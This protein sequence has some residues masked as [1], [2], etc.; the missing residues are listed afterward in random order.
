MG[1]EA[2]TFHQAHIIRRRLRAV[3]AGL[4]AMALMAAFPAWSQSDTSRVLFGPPLAGGEAEQAQTN[5]KEAARPKPLKSEE[6]VRQTVS[7][8]FSADPIAPKTQSPMVLKLQIMLDRLHHSPGVIDGYDGDNLRKALA[9]YQAME[10]IESTGQLD[11]ALWSRMVAA[12][13][14]ASL[15]SYVIQPA[16]VEGPFEREIP[17]DYAEAAKLK[18][19]AYRGVAEA[20]AERYHMDEDLLRQINPGVSFDKAGETI[21]V[22]DVGAPI[23]TKVAR[24]VADKALK[25]LRG[26]DEAGKLVVAYPATIGSEDLPSPSG[27]HV[28]KTVVKNPDYSYRPDVNFKQGDNDKPLRLAPG[29]NNP[30][31]SVWIGL[32]APTYGIHGTPEPSKI[33]KTGSHGCVRLTNWDA[34]ELLKLVSPGVT[35]EFMGGEETTTT[36]VK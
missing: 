19:M 3:T 7:A 29:P 16:D 36:A 2:G 5:A 23:E 30:V 8:G 34:T 10:G 1:F 22:A 9:G 18:R 4:S 11:E 24:L 15:V 28:V 27:M 21:I 20:L 12:A 6:L 35:V 31:G 33:D 17:H 13:G 32:D 26:Y 14:P 25:Q